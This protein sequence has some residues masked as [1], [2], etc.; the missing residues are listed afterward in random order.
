MARPVGLDLG[1][2]YTRIWTRDKGI[3]L[4]CPSAAAIDSQSHEVVALG[5]E[6]KKMLGK[7]PENIVFHHFLRPIP[8]LTPP[9]RTIAPPPPQRPLPPQGRGLK[10]T[11]TAPAPHRAHRRL[12]QIALNCIKLPKILRQNRPTH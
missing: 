11:A 7:T 8:P 2:V 5:V 9:D 4:R 1:T 3:I 10:F 12:T 6:A